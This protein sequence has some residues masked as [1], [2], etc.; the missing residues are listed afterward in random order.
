MSGSRR[1]SA[2]I[3]KTLKK[4]SANLEEFRAL[5]E[6]SPDA[7]TLKKELKKLQRVRDQV[8]GWIASPDNVCK[9]KT[10]ELER[11]RRDIEVEMERFR[12]FE[13]ESKTKAFSKAG[14]KKA[15]EIDP[16]EE[17]R[18]SAT[19]SI[20]GVVERLHESI[21]KIKA[22]AERS[23]TGGKK[24]KRAKA[25]V[26][27]ETLLSDGMKSLIASHEEHIAKL[28]LTN[29]LIDNLNIQPDV[30]PDLIESMEMYLETC[31]DPDAA[32]LGDWFM[33]DDI[34]LDEHAATA[35]A[36]ALTPTVA[37]AMHLH[38][39]EASHAASNKDKESA[40]IKPDST[41]EKKKLS[42]KEKKELEKAAKDKD[43]AAKKETSPGK[44]D[45]AKQ[46]VAALVPSA[47]PAAPAAKAPGDGAGMRATVASP[48]TGFLAVT[49]ASARKQ[50]PQPPTA[51]ADAT[52]SQPVASATT[53]AKHAAGV[54]APSLQE[55]PG[56]AS[57][58]TA[59]VAPVRQARHV[60]APAVETASTAPSPAVQPAAEAATEGVAVVASKTAALRLKGASSAVAPPSPQRPPAQSLKR[61]KTPQVTPA[62]S[63]VMAAPTVTNAALA[64]P[65][66]L[67]AE[68]GSAVGGHSQPVTPEPPRAIDSASAVLSTPPPQRS[69]PLAAGVATPSSLQSQGVVPGSPAPAMPPPNSHPPMPPPRLTMLLQQLS[70]PLPPLVTADARPMLSRKSM[71]NLL[72]HAL[73]QVPLDED[74]PPVV[75][76][77][78][79]VDGSVPAASDA[80]PWDHLPRTTRRVRLPWAAPASWP[81]EERPWMAHR[82]E[83]AR[84]YSSLDTE[85]LLFAFHFQQGGFLQ[86]A[87]AQELYRRGWRLDTQ[88]NAFFTR[89]REPREVLP[90]QW[91]RGSYVYFEPSH[92]QQVIV[93]QR[94]AYSDI[95]RMSA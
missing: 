72:Q 3:D 79:A 74:H 77:S 48:A 61:P 92:W 36:A 21:E 8:R 78:A 67:P 7:Q 30:I 46:P 54:A 63:R 24:G 38:A 28:E 17:K 88:R 2:E 94:L 6:K 45:G 65:S 60:V 9:E 75:Q 14:L 84:I 50:T 73:E 64:M 40:N 55:Q 86:L 95:L 1:L 18:K 5:W 59:L 37:A 71:D 68:L 80:A 76:E 16:E 57:T 56:A 81:T 93:D 52:P 42:K 70:T 83:A 11:A 43:T 91:E 58:P 4:L 62:A 87:A 82:E 31:E 32:F 15:P 13:R 49:A 29:R 89:E 26:H 66:A 20:N 39:E 27:V 35:A 25:H 41:K 69:A 44:G 47:A 34:G 85:Q 19:D 12:E 23:S 10:D 22:E 51:S 53:P 33:Y 90:G